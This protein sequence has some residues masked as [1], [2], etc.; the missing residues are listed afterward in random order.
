MGALEILFSSSS[1]SS[2][3][4]SI[5]LFFVR[6]GVPFCLAAEL[7]SKPLPYCCKLGSTLLASSGFF[8]LLTADLE[9]IFHFLLKTWS[10]TSLTSCCRLG[11]HPY[12]AFLLQ[13][14]ST[15]LPSLCRL[16]VH[17]FLL[18]ADLEYIPTFSLQAWSTSLPS[19]CRLGVHTFLLG[20]DME[21]IPNVLLQT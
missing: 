12:P 19:L 17:P 2:S 14:W 20:A 11:V 4:S 13:A 5:L 16:G 15:S 21:Y 1:S 7:L 10:T 9:Y 8:S 3:S 18:A 6:L